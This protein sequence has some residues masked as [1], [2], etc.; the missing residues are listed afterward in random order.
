MSDDLTLPPAVDRK[1]RHRLLI[2]GILAVCLV[3]AVLYWRYQGTLITS[4]QAQVEGQTYTVMAP[5]SGRVVQVPVLS[6][7]EVRQGDLLI[8]MD[9]APLRAALAE[10]RA[11]LET[12][13]RGGIPSPAASPASLEAE[14]SASLLAEQ[15]RNKEKSARA[16][17]EHWT[18]EHTRAL[19]VLRSPVSADGPERESAAAA[20]AEARQRMEEARRN[21]EEASHRRAAAD[22]QLRRAREAARSVQSGPELVRL[23]QAR[24][25]QAEED[26]RNASVFA[27]EAGRV[28]W[29]NAHAGQI[30]HRGEPVLTLAPASAAEGGRGVPEAVY[31]RTRLKLREGQV[32]RVRLEDGPEREGVV[33]SLSPDTQGGLARINFTEL[34]EG[35]WPGQGAVVTVRTSH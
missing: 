3:L 18:A 12:A 30:V 35:A 11:A 5:V 1:S 7:Q 13:Q 25:A 24:A 17:L 8:G 34:A 16:A 9:D 15:G 20:E 22:A 28:V 33:A 19:L 14:E 23:W 6:G 29:L 32:C 2:L 31:R 4:R 27:P 10:A 26:M 21:L